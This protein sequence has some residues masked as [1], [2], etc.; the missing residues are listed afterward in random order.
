L[1]TELAVYMLCGVSNVILKTITINT[2]GT[3][4][5][6]PMSIIAGIWFYPMFPVTIY[7]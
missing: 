2:S 7:V 4:D 6:A 3:N 5:I 1:I